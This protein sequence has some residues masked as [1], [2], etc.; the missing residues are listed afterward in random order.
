MKFLRLLA[1]GAFCLCNAAM[2]AGFPDKPIKL[3]VPLAPGGSTDMVA[4][5]LGEKMGQALG[6]PVIIENRAGAGGSIG[7]DYVAKSAPDGYSL[8]MGTIGTLAVT[9]SL[10]KSLPYDS[11]AAFAPISLTTGAQF[12]LVANPA[13]QART[14]GELMQLIKDNPGKLNYGSAG[15]GS[16]P[17][18]GM[19]LLQQMTGT[20]ITHVPYRGSGPMISALLGGEVQIGMPDLPSALPHI[21]AGK[22]VA[23]GV[24]STQ[25]AATAPDIPT[26]DESGV[27]GFDV[28]SWL[29]ILAPAGTPQ[30]IIDT[31]NKA[32]TDALRS[33]E[34]RNRLA[35][36]DISVY[37]T[38][39]GEFAA[40]I[41]SER[42]KWDHIVTL[43]GATIN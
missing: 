42:S 4:R 32:A 39:P 30:A 31:L 35:E 26:M 17:H 12:V 8:L 24:T 9:P 28:V 19:E 37:A 7:S 23:L 5:M 15:N 22:L 20:Q 29:G 18:L 21:K 43:S 2:A 11:D 14:V 40:Y 36:S 13:V 33:T 1:L 34:M 10:Y 41:K 27:K 38:P 6:Q 25:R 3:V 16:T